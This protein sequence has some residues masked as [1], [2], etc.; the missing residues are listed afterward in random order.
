MGYTGLA[1]ELAFDHEC[2]HKEGVSTVNV[3]ITEKKQH[4]LLKSVILKIFLLNL[5][6]L[7]KILKK[8]LK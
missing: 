5:F 2:D 6:G 3:G 7:F 8:R 4:L 1:V